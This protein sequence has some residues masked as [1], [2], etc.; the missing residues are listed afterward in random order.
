M[1][2]DRFPDFVAFLNAMPRTEVA[3]HGL[4]HLHPGPQ[5]AIE[6]Q[7]RPARTYDSPRRRP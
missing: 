5:L 6:F 4:H 3:A 7:D 1:R 2:V